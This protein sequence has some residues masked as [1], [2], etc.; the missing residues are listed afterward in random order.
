[1]LIGN[2][3]D[4]SDK[5]EVSKE[6]GQILADLN[7]IELFMETSAR[8]DVDIKEVSLSYINCQFY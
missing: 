8:C 2:K 4:L 1:M 5:R 6:R 3:C 7:G